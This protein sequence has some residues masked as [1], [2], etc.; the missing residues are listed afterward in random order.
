MVLIRI[1]KGR[2]IRVPTEPHGCIRPDLY[3]LSYGT[4]WECF[5]CGM[6]WIVKRDAFGDVAT[7]KRKWFKLKIKEAK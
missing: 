6:Q 5:E 2:Y 3:R 7:W 4:V 1:E